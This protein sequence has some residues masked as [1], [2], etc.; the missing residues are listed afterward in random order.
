MQTVKTPIRD[1]DG[2]VSGV[3]GIFWDIT[4]RKQ[5]EEELEKYRE[6]LEELVEKRTEDLKQEIN[7]RKKTEVELQRAMK[8][9]ESANQA[10]SVFL[11][12]MSHELR[13]PLNAVLGY[14]EILALKETDP[15]KK[16][17]L[18]SIQAS[19]NSLLSLVNDILDLSKIE[20]GKMELSYSAVSIPRLFE[21]MNAIFHEKIASK[22]LQFIIEVGPNVPEALVLDEIRIRQV[23][24]NL[25]SNAV[26]FTDKGRVRLYADAESVEAQHQSQI[27]LRIGVEDTGK[28]IPSDQLEII[29]NPFEQVRGQKI[30]EYSG[31]GLGLSITSNL[32]KRMGG[33]IAVESAEGEGSTFQITIENV[34][35]T[36]TKSL[37]DNRLEEKELNAIRFEPATILIAD[38]IDYNREMLA[39]Y[40]ERWDFKFIFAE[41]GKEALEKSREYR[42]NLILLDM[43]MPVMTGYETAEVLKNDV[44]LSSIP[45]VAVTASALKQDETQICELCDA[46]LRK[47]IT[48]KMLFDEIT[49]HL[50]YSTQ[51]VIEEE[52]KK[53]T[54][55]TDPLITCA[56]TLPR[57]KLNTLKEMLLDGFLDRAVQSIQQQQSEYPQ[58]APF[59]DFAIKQIRTYRET[60]IIDLVNNALER[61]ND[62]ARD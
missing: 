54:V 2:H 5:T 39:A 41:N 52:N 12:N 32:V 28:G 51:S 58:S 23:L 14:S 15:H 18:N 6:H 19:G 34:E 49:K 35:V 50:S 21:E 62:A 30:S 20:A 16:H 53:D 40:L 48:Q 60:D 25:L 37:E 9:A 3:L 55:E 45:I 8:A 29:F 17:Q 42:P 7:E 33:T 11:A 38:D 22:N 10:K 24:I 44:E 46:Y 31:T 36:P 26:K 47:P 1:E 56:A 57:Q 13:T 27:E 43:R 59:F 4:E 61:E